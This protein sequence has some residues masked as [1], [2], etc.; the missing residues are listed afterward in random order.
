MDMGMWLN[1]GGGRELYQEMYDKYGFN[2]KVF[3][4][5]PITMENFMWSKKTPAHH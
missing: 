3:P 4:V 2:V 1:E 5:E